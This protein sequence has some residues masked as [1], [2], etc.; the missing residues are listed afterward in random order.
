MSP[1]LEAQIALNAGSGAVFC[2][3][4]LLTRGTNLQTPLID[5]FGF[6]RPALKAFSVAA[7]FL[8]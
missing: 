3:S 7:V 1:V 8:L 4:S 5:L 2:S 6:P